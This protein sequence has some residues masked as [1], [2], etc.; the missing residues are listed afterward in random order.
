VTTPM[1]GDGAGTPLDQGV[2]TVLFLAAAF[3][4]WI[5]VARL[6]GRSYVRLPRPAARA[7]AA[8][9]G[10]LLILAFILPPILRPDT[11]SARPSTSA[12]L[13]I[14]SPATGEV[15]NGDPAQVPVRLALAGA[16]VVPFNSTRL[17][18]DEGHVHLY[19]DG[20]LISMSFALQQALTV[21][22]GRHIL[23]AEFVAVDHAPFDP[24]V[25][26]SAAFT[27]KRG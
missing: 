11:A 5:A 15:F 13:S 4:G 12:K 7:S 19:L 6:R 20:S 17:V 1:L 3:F 10:A 18:P 26:A 21:V 23:V 27:V 24:R 14:A 16:R 2:A 9:A 22:P 25:Q 8:L